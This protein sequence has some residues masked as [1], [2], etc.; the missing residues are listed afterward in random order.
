LTYTARLNA[1]SARL[2]TIAL[3]ASREIG[4]LAAESVQ[5]QREVKR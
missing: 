1:I 5:L 4:R 2:D 3:L